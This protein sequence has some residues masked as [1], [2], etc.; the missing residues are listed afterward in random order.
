[1]YYV[2]S[3][4]AEDPIDEAFDYAFIATLESHIIPHLGNSRIVDDIIIN[5]GTTLQHASKIHEVAVHHFSSATRASSEQ[6]LPE[7][8]NELNTPKSLKRFQSHELLNV[9]GTTGGFN[10]L[11]RE[12]FSYWCFDLLFLLCSR[13]SDGGPS[14]LILCPD[15]RLT[16]MQGHEPKRRRVAALC[17]PQLLARVNQAILSCCL[18]TDLYGDMPFSRYSASVLQIW[19]NAHQST[20]PGKKS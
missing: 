13:V 17:M 19:I 8:S 15:R 10:I 9:I 6:T 2:S 11:P 4:A 20:A 14:S 16:L 3:T 18:D 5:L 1:M 7:R 12:R